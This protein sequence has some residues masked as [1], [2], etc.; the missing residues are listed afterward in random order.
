MV[1]W[2]QGDT[3]T[4][5]FLNTSF[6]PI[7]YWCPSRYCSHLASSGCTTWD[8]CYL[9]GGHPRGCTTAPCKPSAP[10]QGAQLPCVMVTGAHPLA[11]PGDQDED[12][13]PS[14]SSSASPSAR[15]QEARQEEYTSLQ[16]SGDSSQLHHVVTWQTFVPHQC[17]ALF[18]ALEMEER[19]K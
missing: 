1:S 4:C 11:P 13:L 3:H 18:W 5:Q 9:L 8:T 15:A 16:T 17:Q 10:Q 12:S 2:P 7:W 19:T 14:A 6:A